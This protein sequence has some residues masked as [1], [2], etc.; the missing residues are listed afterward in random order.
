[1]IDEDEDKKEF[2][3]SEDYI[4]RTAVEE[5]GGSDPVIDSLEQ[6][7]SGS[8]TEVKARCEALTRQ[9]N[10]LGPS[11]NGEKD[12]QAMNSFLDKDLEAALDSFDNFFAVDVWCLIADCMDAPRIS[13]FLPRN[14]THGAYQMSKMYNAVHIV[15]NW[16]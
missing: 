16:F 14:N 6:Y 4:L 7:L 12:E 13:S 15:I 11:K 3:D 10:V 9:Q 2:R 1:M 5:I 8:P